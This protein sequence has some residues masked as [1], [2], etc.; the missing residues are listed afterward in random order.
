M[1]ES[2]IVKKGEVSLQYLVDKLKREA[3]RGLGAIGCFVG[4]VR[5]VSSDGPVER[6]E[7]EAAE[8]AEG[9]MLKIAEDIEKIQGI[10]RVI[11]YHVIDELRPG[12]DAIYVVVGGR[13]RKEVFEALPKIMNRIKREALIWK[14]EIT[15][16][17]GRWV[18]G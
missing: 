18:K 16:T 8:S 4:V 10:L 12:E 1:A 2:R 14:K 17:G 3:G 13:H 7:Y 6:L 9:E 5:G 11:I 15:A